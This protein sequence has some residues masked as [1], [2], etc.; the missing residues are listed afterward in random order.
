MVR[1]AYPV[2]LFLI[3]SYSLCTKIYPTGA[4]EVWDFYHPYEIDIIKYFAVFY[5]SV[6]CNIVYTLKVPVGF[7]YTFLN[8]AFSAGG[9]FLHVK[10]IMNVLCQ[11]IIIIYKQVTNEISII[12]F[13]KPL[14][15]FNWIFFFNLFILRI[16]SN[17]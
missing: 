6:T 16:F 11:S 1:G 2:L 4:S 8:I 14:L 7:F 3:T 15:I 9:F 5:L 17:F 12:M 10:L 13:L